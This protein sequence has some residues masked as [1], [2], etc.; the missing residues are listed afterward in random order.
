M[1]SD[2]GI[3]TD[4]VKGAGFLVSATTA[5]G[6]TWRGRARWEPSEEDIP[7]GPQ[8]VAGLASA[9]ALAF[10]WSFYADSSHLPGLKLISTWSVGSCILGLIIYGYLIS[11]QT[12]YGPHALSGPGVTD[13]P[14]RKIIGGLW[15]LPGPR[16]LAR[17]T[18]N[19]ITTQEQLDNSDHNPDKIW[20]RPSRGLAKTTFVVFYL[21]LTVAGTVALTSASMLII[22]KDQSTPPPKDKQVVNVALFLNGEVYYT[23]EVLEVV[24]SHLRESLVNTGYT[25]VFEYAVGYPE[26]ARMLDNQRVLKDL[27]DRFP[28][29]RPDYLITVGTAV[30]EVA[31]G[32]YLN[33]IP[34]VF[35]AVTDPIRSK[36]VRSF[37]ADESRGNIAG[38]VYGVPL[39]KFL[40]YFQR[41]FPGKKFGFIFN[42]SYPQ[43]IAFKDQVMA[44]GPHLLPPMQVWPIEVTEPRLSESQQTAADIFF[45]RYYLMDK[46]QQFLSNSDKPFVAGDISNVYKGALAC[47]N[48]DSKELGRIAVDKI[49]LPNLLKG[50]ALHD[51]PVLYPN[52]VV[53][54]INLRAARRY[55]IS[56]SQVA[57]D[58]AQVVVR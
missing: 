57:I 17:R 48:T 5:I 58:D 37:D 29:S 16:R 35:V 41:A 31:Y 1:T 33:K 11:V 2:Y 6:L 20:S 53:T 30:S 24:I 10:L 9:V 7:R 22:Y 28:N 39:D 14:R 50:T 43:D 23:R 45:G 55:G 15:L 36:L 42:K 18:A 26:T 27:L 25:P 3:F 49:I 52:R 12:Y 13:S 32:L 19:P 44:V 47:I 38:V 21:V 40:G 54:G 34:I 4:L 56:I 8:K 51:V 46:L